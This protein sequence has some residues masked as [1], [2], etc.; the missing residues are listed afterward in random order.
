MSAVDYTMNEVKMTG[1]RVCPN[2]VIRHDAETTM[3][4][5]ARVACC[6]STDNRSFHRNNIAIIIPD[7]CVKQAGSPKGRYTLLHL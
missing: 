5:W 7:I 1:V 4:M 3:V 6:L 2:T